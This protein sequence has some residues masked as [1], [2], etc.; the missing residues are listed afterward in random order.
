[1]RFFH[2]FFSISIHSLVKRETSCVVERKGS[3][4]ISIH[5]LVKRETSQLRFNHSER[6]ISIHSLVKRET[7]FPA[8]RFWQR[9][10][11]NPLP[12][13]EGDR[14][15]IPDTIHNVNFNP[16]PRKEGDRKYS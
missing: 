8:M 7:G 16:L 4:D 9:K 5:S 1:M 2:L 6:N 13:K 11:F 12:R 3:V 15:T 14:N 10:H